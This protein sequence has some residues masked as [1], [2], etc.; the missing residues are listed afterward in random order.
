MAFH[1][2]GAGDTILRSA[3]RNQVGSTVKRLNRAG[4]VENIGAGRASKWSLSD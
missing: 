3:I 4:A 2:R 1:S